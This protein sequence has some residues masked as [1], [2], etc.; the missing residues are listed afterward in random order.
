MR[1]TELKIEGEKKEAILVAGGAGFKIYSASDLDGWVL[2]I[3]RKVLVV[4][5]SSPDFKTVSR[6]VNLKYQ[7]TSELDVIKNDFNSL[8]ARSQT[9]KTPDLEPNL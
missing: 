8:I 4:R 5:E 9:P 1:T 3:G 7:P 2:V 6:Y